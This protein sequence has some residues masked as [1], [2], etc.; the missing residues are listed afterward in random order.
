MVY[1]DKLLTPASV[2]AFTSTSNVGPAA[3]FPELMTI[4]RGFNSELCT[5]DS[6][7]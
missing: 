2:N 5:N 4:L 6:N 1:A 7:F 3:P